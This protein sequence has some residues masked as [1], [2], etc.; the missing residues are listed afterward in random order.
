[1]PAAFHGI[2][3]TRIGTRLSGPKARVLL[4]GKRLPALG[5]DHFR[6]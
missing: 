4:D 2:P 5:H 3:L 1:V 6:K